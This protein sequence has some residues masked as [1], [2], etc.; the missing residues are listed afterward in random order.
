MSASCLVSIIIPIYNAVKYVQQAIDSCLAQTHDQVEIIIQD[1]CSNDGTWELLNKLY[2]DESKVVLFRNP[3]NLGIGENWNVA[4]AKATGDYFV[5]F[6]GDDIMHP[7]MV[8]GFLS[9]LDSDSTLDIITGKFEVLVTGTSRTFVYPDHVGLVGGLVSNLYSQ[10]YFRSAFHWNFSLVR[11]ELLKKVEFDDGN[12]FLNTQV[13]DYELWYRCYLEGAK[14]YF[15][16]TQ[17]WGYY[18]RHES[19][20]SSKP[21]GETRSFL[22]DFLDYHQDSFKNKSGF[23]YTTMLARRFLSF[24]NNTKHFEKDV[25]Y[26]YVKRLAQ[27]VL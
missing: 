23:N 5:I 8:A 20:S 7:N 27:S 1:D 2:A 12:L 19:N 26:L 14:V 13:C 16:D 17:I 15:D 4:Y 18:R 21:N 10:L 11:K 6:N 25:F 22:K 3:R 9:R 24:C